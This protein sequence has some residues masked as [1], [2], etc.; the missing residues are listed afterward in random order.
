MVV[1][2]PENSA[3][4]DVAPSRRGE[5]RSVALCLALALPV[6]IAASA[7]LL[8]SAG[9]VDTLPRREWILPSAYVALVVALFV[10]GVFAAIGARVETSVYGRRRVPRMRAWLASF[11]LA[12]FGALV[13]F[14]AIGIGAPPSLQTVLGI[15]VVAAILLTAVLARRLLAALAEKLL[16]AF[17]AWLMILVAPVAWPNP[18]VQAFS[19]WLLWL[20]RQSGVIA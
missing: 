13:F 18:V 1:P 6:G 16:I 4:A 2:A 10:A 15:L 17:F 5:G 8:I 12:P 3:L 9:L 7:G 11:G 19:E 20:L 14:F